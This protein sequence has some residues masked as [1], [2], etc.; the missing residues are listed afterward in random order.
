M[1]SAARN[2]SPQRITQTYMPELSDL[3]SGNENLKFRVRQAESEHDLI[4]GAGRRTA[5]M[6]ISAL[7]QS[8]TEFFRRNVVLIRSIIAKDGVL[9]LHLR[10][11]LCTKL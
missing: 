7:S 11:S 10:E 8:H 1:F 6:E 3:P 2:K 9:H 5:K 4:R